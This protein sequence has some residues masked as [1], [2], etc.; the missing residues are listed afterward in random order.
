L[1]EIKMAD[2]NK[3][4]DL[5]YLEKIAF[6]DYAGARILWNLNI[7]FPALHLLHESVEKYLKIL[8]ASS[9][10][11]CSKDDLNKK[12]KKLNHNTNLVFED[13]SLDYQNRLKKSLRKKWLKLY[14]LEGIRYGHDT[15][16]ISYDEDS[17]RGAELFIKEIRLLLGRSIG[18]S[19][20]EDF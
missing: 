9:R 4:I 3:N 20:F 2:Y 11:F 13:L 16:L 5:N 1:G 10:D 19:T 17:F 18:E 14:V 12:L 15:Q 7:F 6:Q 8:W